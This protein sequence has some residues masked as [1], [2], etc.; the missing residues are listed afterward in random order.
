M[1]NIVLHRKPNITRYTIVCFALIA[2]LPLPCSQVT[3]FPSK[4]VKE[5]LLS[6]N[7][8]NNT[9]PSNVSYAYTKKQ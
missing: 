9:W 3:H 2:C 1:G 8:S 4:Q 6:L 5:L 7:G